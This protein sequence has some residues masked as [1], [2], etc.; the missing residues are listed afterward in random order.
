MRVLTL[1]L[2]LM[3]SVAAF[4]ADKKQQKDYVHSVQ[5][6][7]RWAGFNNAVVSV[8]GKS[9][10]VL[11]VWI[12][13]ANQDGMRLLE[14]NCVEPIRQ[15]LREAGFRSVEIRNGYIRWAPVWKWTISLRR[16][17]DPLQ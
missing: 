12:P 2:M 3:L 6:Q 7:M 1:M 4:A 16:W 15:Q 11:L 13:D 8:T 14:A 9:K 17:D 10:D 5:Q